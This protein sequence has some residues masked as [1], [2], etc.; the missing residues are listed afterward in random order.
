MW[1]VLCSWQT[2]EAVSQ[3][4]VWPVWCIYCCRFLHRWIHLINSQK[5]NFRHS[6]LCW[7]FV[8][9]LGDKTNQTEWLLIRNIVLCWMLWF[10]PW[11][12]LSSI[13]TPRSTDNINFISQSL[14]IVFTSHWERIAIEAFTCHGSISS[15]ICYNS[16]ECVQIRLN[17]NNFSSYNMWCEH[18]I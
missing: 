18:H 11:E 9:K 17:E 4:L 12:A 2:I 1:S 8:R 13:I 7:C 10:Y 3:S 14:L 6:A 16:V 15:K 5:G